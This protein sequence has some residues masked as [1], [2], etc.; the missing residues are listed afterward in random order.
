MLWC[1]ALRRILVPPCSGRQWILQLLWPGLQAQICV[2]PLLHN[3][4]S[5]LPHSIYGVLDGRVHGT[6]HLYTDMHDA[7]LAIAPSL[8]LHGMTHTSA[9]YCCQQTPNRASSKITVCGAGCHLSPE[10][11]F[12]SLAHPQEARLAWIYVVYAFQWS[13]YW[14]FRASVGAWCATMQLHIFKRVQA[15]ARLADEV[16]STS[17]NSGQGPTSG[18]PPTCCNR[19]HWRS[20]HQQ[21]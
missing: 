12:V 1:A 11:A 2:S 3:H 8:E 6:G 14:P 20:L 17:C 16:P 21:C 15:T 4:H 13:V 5:W 19:S 18:L 10:C 7:H 9:I